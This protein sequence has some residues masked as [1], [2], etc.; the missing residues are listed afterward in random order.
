VIVNGH[1]MTGGGKAHLSNAV[2]ESIFGCPMFG[3]FNVRTI[4]DIKTLTPTLM[5]QK[6]GCRYY[7]VR[8]DGQYDAWAWRRQK[9]FMTGTK[10]ELISKEL[11]PDILKHKTITM[12]IT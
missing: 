3:T 12:E 11:L 4:K 7:H 2:H 5:N 10:W 8:I 6:T 9:S 1:Y